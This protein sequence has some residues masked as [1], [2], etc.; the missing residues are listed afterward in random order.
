M[1]M[2]CIWDTDLLTPEKQNKTK[3]NTIT[4]TALGS[5]AWE[6][7]T[8]SFSSSYINELAEQSQTIYT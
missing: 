5:P 1:N 3:H 4:Q 8:A 7:L 6:F 2:Y